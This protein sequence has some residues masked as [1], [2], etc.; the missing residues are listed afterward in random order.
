MS[1]DFIGIDFGTSNCAVAAL[2][3]NLPTLIVVDENSDNPYKIRSA[4]YLAHDE[5]GADSH[6]AKANEQTLNDMLAAGEI[7]LE[8]KV[9]K[10]F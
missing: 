8:S 5:S 3:D 1:A 10:P 7:L 6:D 2:V 9:L 4:I